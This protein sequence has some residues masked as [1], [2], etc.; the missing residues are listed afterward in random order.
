MLKEIYE[1]PDSLMMSVNGRVD[2]EKEEVTL[3]GLTVPKP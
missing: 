1:Q 3:S 2:F